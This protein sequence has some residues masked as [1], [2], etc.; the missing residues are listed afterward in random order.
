MVSVELNARLTAAAAVLEDYERALDADAA[1]GSQVHYAI[2]AGRL[3]SHIRLLIEVK[4][5]RSESELGKLAEIRAVLREAL[6]NEHADRQQ[7]LE[8]ID[9]IMRVAR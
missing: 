8:Q 7:A 3:A 4:G 9:E 2:W 1:T 5:A 6:S